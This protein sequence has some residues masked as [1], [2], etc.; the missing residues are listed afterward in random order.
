M[1]S[2][3]RLQK[4]I[5]G[6]TRNHAESRG[7]TPGS[8]K[9]YKVILAQEAGSRGI[10]RNHAESRCLFLAYDARHCMQL[11]KPRCPTC[12]NC[13]ESYSFVTINVLMCDIVGG[14][15]LIFKITQCRDHPDTAHS[16]QKLLFAANSCSSLAAICGTSPTG[17]LVWMHTA[18]GVAWYYI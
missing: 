17:R 6:I 3:G 11:M 13:A 5:S 14:G 15:A 8:V 10:T 9:V 16:M 2:I 12:S 4:G 18:L 7:I 1:C